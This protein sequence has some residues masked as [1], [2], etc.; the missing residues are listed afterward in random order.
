VS[1]HAPAEGGEL[2]TRPFRFQGERLVLNFITAAKGA[3]RV[4]L[5][6]QDGK[7][8]EGLTLADCPPLQ[9]DAVD[10]SVTWKPSADLRKWA[11]KPVRLRFELKDADLFSFRFP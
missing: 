2:L 4:E 10:Q 6:D 9:G 5:Q 7:P 11:G 1:V 8:L 3:V